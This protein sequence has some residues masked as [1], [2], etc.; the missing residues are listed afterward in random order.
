MNN[1]ELLDL[2]KTNLKTC[3]EGKFDAN[4]YVW[5]TIDRS[6]L[7]DAS[8]FIKEQFK[9]KNIMLTQ[10][11]G[12]DLPEQSGMELLY[13]WWELDDRLFF[14]VKTFLPYDNL[15]IETIGDDW[16]AAHWHER[17]THE[18]LGIKFLGHNNLTI[19][20]LP[21]ELWGKYPLRKSFKIQS[22]EE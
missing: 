18:M 14:T 15:E 5:L 1:Q 4:G 22:M 21:D 17:E 7:K 12:T 19:F 8:K 20:L 16:P 2:L 3:K 10:M 6:E 11:F 13:T 9:D